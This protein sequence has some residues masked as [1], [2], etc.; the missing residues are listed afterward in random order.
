MIPGEKFAEV[1][2]LEENLD[3]E[4]I[5]ELFIAAVMISDKWILE[6]AKKA[7]PAFE[8]I[9]PAGMMAKEGLWYKDGRVWIPDRDGLWPR[10]MEMYHDTGPVGHLG[11][12]GTL[13]LVSRYY[14]KPGLT[15]YV[16][17]YVEGCREC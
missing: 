5:W 17:R 9:R 15:Q 4:E 2:A 12:T 13:D 3:M 1:A 6:Q 16:K 8:K 11:V 7:Y 10:I 14:W